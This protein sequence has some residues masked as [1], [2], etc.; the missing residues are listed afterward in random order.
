MIKT[1]KMVTAIVFDTSDAQAIKVK[2]A[3]KFLKLLEVGIKVN[4]SE[5]PPSDFKLYE[6]NGLYP[7]DEYTEEVIKDKISELSGSE[8]IGWAGLE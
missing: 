4:T 7:E 5:N 2:E 3:M 8:F 1:Y 6:I